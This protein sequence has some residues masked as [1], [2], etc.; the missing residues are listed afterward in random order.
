MCRCD[1]R[2]VGEVARNV[3]NRRI[4]AAVAGEVVSTAHQVQDPNA[5]VQ[6][7]RLVT[8]LA[9]PTAMDKAINHVSRCLAAVAQVAKAVLLNESPTGRNGI[10]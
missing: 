8:H 9:V 3:V 2:D 5:H 4:E 10:A 1:A 7:G 6:N